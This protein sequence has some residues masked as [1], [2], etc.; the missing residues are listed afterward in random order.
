MHHIG[1]EAAQASLDAAAIGVLSQQPG[2]PQQA[3][4]ILQG[5]RFGLD[6]LRKRGP[7][8]FGVVLTHLTPLQIGAVLTEQQIHLIPGFGVLAEGFGSICLLL[9]DQFRLLGI[10]IGRGDLLGKGGL[11]QLLAAVVGHPLGLQ[12]GAE[13]ADPH[14]TGKTLQFHGARGTWIDVALALLHLGLEALLALVETLEVGKPLH[15]AGGDL[16]EGVLHPGGEARIHQ[17]GEVVL[18]QGG[19]REGREAGGEGVVLEG[20]VA[21]VHDRADDAGVGGGTADAF[22]LQHLH[23]GGLAVAGRGLGLVTEGLHPP[24][25][26]AVAHRQGRQQHFLAFQRRI[27]IIAAL[28]VGA[29]EAG[30]VDP[31]AAGAEGATGGLQ[32]DRQHRETGIGHLAGH[33]ALP[34]QF[35]ERQI[36][37]IETGFGGG[38]ERLSRRPDRLMGLLGIAGLGA[39]LTRRRA[40]EFLAVFLGNAAAGRRDRLVGKMHRVGAHVGDVALFV[41]R[42]GGAHRLAGGEPQLAVGLLLQRAGGEGRHGLAHRGLLLHRRHPPGGSFHSGLKL[43]GLGLAEQLHLAAGLE[44]TGGLVEIGTA[45]D[46]LAPKVG[47]LGLE[48]RSRLF[49]PGFQIPVTAASEGPP[50]AL[51]LHQQAH[52]HRLHAACREAPG[53]LFPE[54]GRKRVAHQAVEDPPRLLGVHQLHVELAGAVQGAPDRLPGDLVEHHPLHRHLGSEQL[55]EMPADALSFPVLVRGQ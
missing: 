13:A 33:G 23:Q 16:I 51:P 48:G 31:L 54:Q 22:L 45:G 38:P 18:Q 21:P 47:E 14:H 2:Q 39:E 41:E 42:L 43:P 53:H 27:G 8:G 50:C 35:V 19:H 5:H 28:H 36:P 11:E 1:P 26:G 4:G 37:A 44:G 17:V 46:P 30:E 49:E 6:A 10:E 3:E 25:G 24:A 9:E 7:F 52:R 12:V 55:Q 29:E 15:L 20:G 34:D 32:V 40:E